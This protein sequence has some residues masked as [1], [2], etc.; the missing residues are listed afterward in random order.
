MKKSYVYYCRSY[1]LKTLVSQE[2]NLLLNIRI[3]RPGKCSIR[4]LA[5]Q[6]YKNGTLRLCFFKMVE[7]MQ[8]LGAKKT[9]CLVGLR[10]I[11]ANY[12]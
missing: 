2:K 5:L 12:I 10:Q 3:F 9:N 8:F 6:D 11:Y 4:F 7:N 1:F